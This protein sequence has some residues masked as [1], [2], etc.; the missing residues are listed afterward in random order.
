MGHISSLISPF[1]L[2]VSV[3]SQE[4][5]QSYHVLVCRGSRFCLFLQC[6]D[7]ILELFRQCGSFR[8]APTVW[9]FQSCSD[10]VV[11]L[12][13]FRHCGSF[14]TVPTVWQS[15]NCSDS[16]VVLELFRQCGSF[17]TVP[18]VW[19]FQNCSNSVVVLELFRQCG[20][21]RTVQTV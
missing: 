5:E 11:V 6:I 2:E 10:S 14:R 13:L 7:S 12:E 17:R 8:A 20:S 15:Q 21:F 4:N 18:I 9:Q 3:P 19:Q 1:F 16:V